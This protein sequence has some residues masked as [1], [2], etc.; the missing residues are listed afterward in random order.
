MQTAVEKWGDSLAIKIPQKIAKNLNL[1]NNSMLNLQE[2]DGKIILEKKQ[3]LS[4]LCSKITKENLNTQ[5]E[6]IIYGKE[7]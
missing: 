2:I 1:K 6:S 4:S 5:C 7:W 3:D